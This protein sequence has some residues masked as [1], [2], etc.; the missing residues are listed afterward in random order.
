MGP[1]KQ[2]GIRFASREETRVAMTYRDWKITAY[3]SYLGYH[4]QYTSPI[5]KLHNTSA[6]FTT[7]QQAISYA[8]MSID[9]LLDC[10]RTL[11]ES[12]TAIPVVCAAAG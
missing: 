1:V 9:S 11:L 6:Y 4:A 12:G 3:S 10:E 8:K 7:D 2:N 5:G